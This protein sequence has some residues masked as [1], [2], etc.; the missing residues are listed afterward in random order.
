[1]LLSVSSLYLLLQV[2]AYLKRNKQQITLEQ[3]QLEQYLRL[4]EQPVSR[5]AA[6]AAAL[7]SPAAMAAVSNCVGACMRPAV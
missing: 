6:A 4:R 1:M 3:Q 7:T 2:P 5:A